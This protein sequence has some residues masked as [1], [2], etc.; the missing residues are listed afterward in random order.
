MEIGRGRGSAVAGM[1]MG[2]IERKKKMREKR[3]RTG[4]AARGV[5]RSEA[6][7][8]YLVRK[9]P[10]G[11]AGSRARRLNDHQESRDGGATQCRMLPSEPCCKGGS[12]SIWSD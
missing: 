11:I 1:E 8:A 2:D 6:G 3:T 5:G 9:G 7:Y 10:T 4:D 12:V